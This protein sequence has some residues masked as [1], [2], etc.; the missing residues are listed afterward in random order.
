M[1]QPGPVIIEPDR[2]KDPDRPL[3]DHTRRKVQDVRLEAPIRGHIVDLSES[4]LGI[5]SPQPL[6]V[7]K[8]YVF[9]FNTRRARPEF[10]GEVRWCRLE[11]FGSG[12][13]APVYRAG[14]ALVDR[15]DESAP[16]P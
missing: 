16:T 11:S 15:D 6:E 13:A 7:R 3:R 12:E 10:L 5:E 8:R 2:Q 1:L 14:I 9:R 4:G